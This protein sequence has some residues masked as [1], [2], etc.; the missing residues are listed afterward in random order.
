MDQQ[1]RLKAQ[2]IHDDACARY[3]Q[4]IRTNAYQQVANGLSRRSIE[5]LRL[6]A[7]ALLGS[8]FCRVTNQRWNKAAREWLLSLN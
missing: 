6:F 3:A 2:L 8:P 1:I 5:R 7:L 4:A